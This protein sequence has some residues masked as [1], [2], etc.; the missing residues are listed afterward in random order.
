[1]NLETLAE[2]AALAVAVWTLWSRVGRIERRLDLLADHLHAP[3]PPRGNHGKAALLLALLILTGLAAACGSFRLSKV[4]SPFFT[5]EGID[6]RG[7]WRP[8]GTNTPAK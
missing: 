7:P 5:V 2:P 4:S 6:A 1:M 3:K 8:S